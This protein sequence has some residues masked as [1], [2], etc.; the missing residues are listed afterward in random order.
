MIKEN[1]SLRP[2]KANIKKA[3]AENRNDK[4]LKYYLLKT[5]SS[6]SRP[7]YFFKQ[8]YLNIHTKNKM[9]LIKKPQQNIIINI[10]ISR[11]ILSCRLV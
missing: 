3:F 2:T 8:V 5:I 4:K 6:L 7:P 9:N 1:K 10:I 11:G